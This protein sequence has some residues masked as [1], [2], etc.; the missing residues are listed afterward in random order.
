M[1]YVGQVIKLYTLHLYGGLCQLHL[2]KTRRE[3]RKISVKIFLH[4]DHV[5]SSR[6]WFYQLTFFLSKNGGRPRKDKNEE[7]WILSSRNSYQPW[8]CHIIFPHK[9]D[10]IRSKYSINITN[11]I[12]NVHSYLYE[13]SFQ[14]SVQ[15]IAHMDIKYRKSL[16]T[17]NVTWH[18]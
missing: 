4:P 3:K 13:L 12:Q 5:E 16:W 18:Q 8:P 14:M 11:A 10:K 7:I 2:N 6:I 1:K 9:R 17:K 15:I